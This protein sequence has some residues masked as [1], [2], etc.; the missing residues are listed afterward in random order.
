MFLEMGSLMDL[1][2]GI[3]DG[4]LFFHHFPRIEMKLAGL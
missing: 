1:F 4:F 3:H 2:D